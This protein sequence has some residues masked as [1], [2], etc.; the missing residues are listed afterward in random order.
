MK[1]KIYP[2]PDTQYAIRTFRQLNNE[3]GCLFNEKVTKSSVTFRKNK[4][5]S[6]NVQTNVISFITMNYKNFISL[7]KVKNKPNQTQ[8]KAN[9][10]PIPERPKMNIRNAVTMN[11]KI[12]PR[13]PGE[14][15]K[16]KQTQSKPICL[17][18]VWFLPNCPP[19]EQGEV[20]NSRANAGIEYPDSHP[21]RNNTCY[22]ADSLVADRF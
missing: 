5:N 18:P 19:I 14:K 21:V 20:G 9:S 6:P 22:A 10:N 1:S 12:S 13:L 2:I 11:Y 3:K 4:P 16:P 17:L 15:T 8:F 7:T